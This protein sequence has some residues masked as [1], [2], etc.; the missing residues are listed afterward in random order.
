LFA[1]RV[2]NKRVQRTRLR[3]PLTRH[4]LGGQGSLVTLIAAGLACLIAS[5]RLGYGA[6]SM[7]A[8]DAKRELMER[9]FKI[10]T[11]T[12]DIPE[13]V[14]VLLAALTKT[15]GKVLAEPGEKYQETDVVS[16]AGLPRRRLIFA[17]NGK[18]IYIV[19]YEMGGIG[20]SQHVIVVEFVPGQIALV[21][22]AVLDRRVDNLTEL[23]DSVRKGQ[24][25]DGSAYAF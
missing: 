15:K 24:Y 11:K 17:G 14:I 18:G 23:R 2:P 19:N 13:P 10:V 4:P 16:E 7:S 9:E 22:R 25:R 20:H 3:S 6:D 5:G 21:W 12:K 8:A 1:C